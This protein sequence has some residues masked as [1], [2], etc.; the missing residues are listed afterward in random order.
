MTL[1]NIVVC[2]TTTLGFLF[3]LLVCRIGVTGDDVP[4]V[5]ETREEAQAAESDVDERV[6]RAETALDPY[7][8][9]LVTV[10]SKVHVSLLG[11]CC[12]DGWLHSLCGEEGLRAG[13]TSERREKDGQEAQED[14]AAAHV[15]RSGIR[16]VGVIDGVCARRRMRRGEG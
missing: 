14:I 2:H 12:A 5:D 10:W 4:G 7:C 1:L 6:G 8:N 16:L 15:V 3:D 9:L 13:L 11:P